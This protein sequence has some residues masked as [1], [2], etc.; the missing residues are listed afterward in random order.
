MAFS[1]LDC[2]R[3]W[4]GGVST[5]ATDR[6]CCLVWVRNND[7]QEQ[8]LKPD[9]ETHPEAKFDCEEALLSL[10]LFDLISLPPLRKIE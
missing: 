9:P 8:R 1:G 2:F 5:D 7:R 6:T 3:S 10:S 4:I